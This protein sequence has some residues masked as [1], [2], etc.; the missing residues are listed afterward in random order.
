MKSKIVSTLLQNWIPKI[1]S[2]LIALFIVLAV[3]FMNVNDRVVTLPLNVLLPEGY[4]AVSL[5]PDTVEA[6]ITGPDSI[7]YLVDPSEISASAD[8]S[9]V[10]GSGIARVPVMLEYQENIYTRDGLV[11]SARPSS[12][13]IL[14]EEK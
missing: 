13:R 14:F 3:R 11:V 1:F 8:F 6:V 4:E 7:I 9:S 12:V 10:S 2:L 5:V